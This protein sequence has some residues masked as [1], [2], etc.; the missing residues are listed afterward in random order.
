MSPEEFLHRLADL[1]CVL[2]RHQGKI[3]GAIL[4]MIL[5]GLTFGIC[6]GLLSAS[7]TFVMLPI[8]PFAFMAA[9]IGCVI[10]LVRTARRQQ[11]EL[12]DMLESFNRDSVPRGIQW[13]IHHSHH[14]KRKTFYVLVNT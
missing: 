13:R 5:S 11:C 8:L 10:I 3:R 12:R 14:H 2:K 9:M 6:M 4:A 1:N 7:Q